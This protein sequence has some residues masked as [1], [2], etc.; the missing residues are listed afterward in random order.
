MGV[1]AEAL[2]GESRLLHHTS[3]PPVRWVRH[4]DDP[5]QADIVEAELE[6]CTRP[7]GGQPLSPE[8]T[9]QLKA[10]LHIVG[11]GQSVSRLSPIWPIHA[12]VLRSR[13]AKAPKPSS[14]HCR[15]WWAAK[16]MTRSGV[17]GR[18][19]RLTSGSEKSSR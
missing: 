3:G 16:A 7:F 18:M 15:R 17:T 13:A 9:L 14:S 4:A 8:W 12:P 6:T 19:Y 10:N 5:A 2:E 11:S 1:V